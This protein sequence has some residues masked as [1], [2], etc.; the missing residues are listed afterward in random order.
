MQPRSTTFDST[1]LPDPPQVSVSGIA[2]Q[3]VI[4][5]P[6]NASEIYELTVFETEDLGVPTELVVGWISDDLGLNWIEV[7]VRNG[8]AKVVLRVDQPCSVPALPKPAEISVSLVELTGD[9]GLKPK[10][11]AP[12]WDRVCL[13]DQV[14]MVA[15]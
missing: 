13:D 10:H 2:R 15:H 11:R 5:S 3:T 7:D 8:L 14:V 12:E 4:E 6:Q 9:V 1:S